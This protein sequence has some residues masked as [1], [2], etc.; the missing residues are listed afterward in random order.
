MFLALRYRAFVG[1]FDTD[2]RRRQALR[3][4]RERAR[5]LGRLATAGLSVVVLVGGA[6]TAAGLISDGR[7]STD[8][9]DKTTVAPA[10]PAS[11]AQVTPAIDAS[12]V[13]TIA[14]VCSAA[15]EAN[16][17]VVRDSRALRKK[18]ASTHSAT[19]AKAAAIKLVDSLT[20]ALLD[21]T[22]VLSS[23]TPPRSLERPYAKAVGALGRN[24]RW[25]QRYSNALS[26]A[27]SPPAVSRILHTF[28]S[29]MPRYQMDRARLRAE[30][31]RM[32]S[33]NCE[34]RKTPTIDPIMP[35]RFYA[36]SAGTLYAG[37]GTFN[38]PQASKVASNPFPVPRLPVP[39]LTHPAPE[40]EP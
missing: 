2:H 21:E 5:R 10:Q 6:A 20:N 30:L 23:V 7:P 40:S 25:T 13:I 8:G 19:V 38:V 26:D 34:L 17:E 27:D 29:Q 15:N 36:S 14:K 22:T 32:G 1:R 4:A 33:G 18:F 24:V 39:A 35:P 16:A 9:G 37:T 11:K 28:G 12:F 3:T 31:L